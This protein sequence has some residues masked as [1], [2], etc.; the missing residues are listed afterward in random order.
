MIYVGSALLGSAMVTW[1]LRDNIYN[2]IKR[3]GLLVQNYNSR[4]VPTALGVVLLPGSSL[5]LFPLYLFQ[6][7]NRSHL[8]ALLILLYGMAFIGIVDDLLGERQIKGFKGHMASLVHGHMTTGAFKALIGL[9]LALFSSML[10]YGDVWDLIVNTL[11]IALSANLMNLLDL[12][13]GRCLKGFWFM[14]IMIALF[15]RSSIDMVLFMPLFIATIIYFPIDIRELG[16]L[17]DTGANILGAAVGLAA[18]VNWP[19]SYKWVYLSVLLA[20][21]VLAEHYSLNDL[22]E[23]SRILTF[24]DRM[25]KA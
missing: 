14:M 11:V 7:T 6:R 5:A 18:A 20:A 10:I 15:S 25:G 17:G 3:S 9:M 8:A 2:M 21:H 22:I 24:I 13:P 1:A 19:A 16:M 12:R 4:A 23:R